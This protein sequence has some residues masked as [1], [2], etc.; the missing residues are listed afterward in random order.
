MEY[1]EISTNQDLCPPG[2]HLP[3]S[4]EWDALILALE[5][6]AIAGGYLKDPN[7]QDGFNGLLEGILYQN[8]T[9]SF[10]SDPVTATMFWTSESLNLSTAVARGLNNFRAPLKTN[11]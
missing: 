6:N 3:S 11:C 5:G 2:W 1:Q 10:G 8:K 4:A 9:W 7:I